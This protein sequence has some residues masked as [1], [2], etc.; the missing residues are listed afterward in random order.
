[1]QP[2]ATCSDVLRPAK[3]S[4][5]TIPL[6]ER[7]RMWLLCSWGMDTTAAEFD[8]K[9]RAPRTAGHTIRRQRLVDSL[10]RNLH[11]GV[12]L[13]SAPAGYGKTTLLADFCSDLDIP[14][15]WYSVDSADLD[16]DW[17]TKGIVASVRLHFPEFGRS[18]ESRVSAGEKGPTSLGQLADALARDMR[19]GIPD[20]FLLVLDD[21]HLAEGGAPKGLLDSLLGRM[22]ENCHIIISSRTTVDIPVLPTLLLRGELSSLTVSDLAF[23]AEEIRQ[24]LTDRGL[25]LSDQDI[26]ELTRDTEGWPVSLVLHLHRARAGQPLQAFASLVRE[27]VFGY[28]ASEVYERLPARVRTFL[29]RSSVLEQ[30]EP[31]FC[32]RLLDMNGSQKLLREIQRRNL[33]LSTVQAERPYYRYHPLFRDF[34]QKRF[35]DDNPGEL[36][37]LHGKAAAMFRQDQRWQP[38][39]DHFLAAKRYIQ[40]RD[41]IRS[42]GQE[43]LNGG[44]WTSVSRWIDGLPARFR[45]GDAGLSLLKAQSDVHTGRVDEAARSLTDVIDRSSAPDAWLLRARAL[46]WRSAALRLAGHLPEAKKDIRGAISILET[47]SGPA[48]NLGDAYRRLGIIQME[49][50]RLSTALV[51]LKRALK[52]Y[53]SIFEIGQTAAVHNAM[54]IAYRQLGNLTRSGMHFDFARQGWQRIGNTGALASLLNNLGLVYQCQGDY[55]RALKTLRSGLDNARESGYRRMEACIL[56]SLADILRDIGRYDEGLALY[57]EGLRIAEEVMEVYYIACATAGVGETERLLGHPEKAEI[58]LKQALSQAEEHGRSYECAVFSVR[59]GI[60]EYERGEY[61]KALAILRRALAS[62]K[63]IGDKETMGRAWFHIAH[64]QFLL[65]S[66]AEAKRSLAEASRLADELGYDSFLS[67]EGRNA[68]LLLQ[69]AASQEIGKGRFV[70]VLERVRNW[71]TQRLQA[72]IE[73]GRDLAINP[74][75]D[76]EAYAFGEGRVLVNDRR[77]SD[78]DWRSGRA[79]ELFFYLL[80]SEMAK[81]KEQIAVALWPDMSPAKSTSNFHINLYRAR[82]ALFPGIVALEEG[83]YRIPDGLG[84]WFDVAEFSEIV[85]RIG[86]L[87]KAVGTT[88]ALLQKAADLYSGPFLPGVYSEW[89]ED[90]RRELET[91]YLKVLRALAMSY[92]EAGDFHK[93]VALLDKIAAIDPY[94][95]QWFSE[96]EKWSLAHGCDSALLRGFRWSLNRLKEGDDVGRRAKRLMA[97]GQ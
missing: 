5:D 79:K 2:R 39:I 41:V 92:S 90:M 51:H 17:F 78:S 85:D 48:D 10:H 87:P 59:L 35:A 7:R 37:R 77:V 55:D 89:V 69:Y 31:E 21:Y 68:G 96:M 23:S 73:T 84:I 16:A 61:E 50:G 43:F 65:K 63:Q 60:I 64:T 46:S 1:M 93:A 91:R 42:I 52:Y 29:L 71:D 66:Y 22:P 56:I 18:V 75:S 20:Y 53:S 24:V 25:A 14:V 76:M 19:D 38:A 47:N 70:R 15:C 40:A 97:P 58:L 9:I 74:R 83:R 26:S 6:S 57:E 27:D 72:P 30:I 67:I 86:D 81:T 45:L 13:I 88:T 44:K 28:L 82:H 3:R 62:L 34:L 32:D 80:C 11:A 8:T 49:Q 12:Q 4:A 95:E 36:R 33:F 54:G 94:D